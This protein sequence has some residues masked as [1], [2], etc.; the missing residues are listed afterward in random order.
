M[1]ERL[2]KLL[3]QCAQDI[4]IHTFHSLCLSIL[5]ENFN[6]AGLSENFSVI[7]EQEKALYKEEELTKDMLEFDDLITLTVKLFEE[8][9]EILTRYREN[10]NTSRLMSIRILTQ[11]S[12]NLSGSWFLTMQISV[13]S[14]I[15]IRQSTAFA[16]AAQNFSIILPKITKMSA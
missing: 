16:A 11:T 8:H 7:S 2:Q 1:G 14:G 9:P 12:I 15:L 10:F 6:E 13:Q 4:S 3:P 5:K